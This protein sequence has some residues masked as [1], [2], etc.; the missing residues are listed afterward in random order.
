MKMADWREM[1]V[2]GLLVCERVV[3]VFHVSDSLARLPF[4]RFKVKV[5]ERP[6]GTFFACPNVAVRGP[7]GD[8]EWIG[9]FG[10]TID[11][12]VEDGLRFFFGT[13]ADRQDLTESDFVW[14]DLHDF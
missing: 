7:A 13:W 6:D 14:S 8:A 2:E 9:G 4:A 10:V 5:L 11:E 1:R 12:A 3:A